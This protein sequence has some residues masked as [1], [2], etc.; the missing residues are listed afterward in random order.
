MVNQFKFFKG[1][2]GI[3]FTSIISGRYS[4]PFYVPND[5][6]THGFCVGVHRTQLILHY[7]GDMDIESVMAMTWDLQFR[8]ANYVS[9]NEQII[10]F[11]EDFLNEH[12]S[13]TSIIR[14]A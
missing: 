3:A 2:T 5:A 14:L 12:L 7:E 9:I 13:G 6:Q 8:Y 10:G 11:M 1:P 4:E